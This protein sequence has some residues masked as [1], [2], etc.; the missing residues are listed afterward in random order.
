MSAWEDFKSF[1][2]ELF[3][4]QVRCPAVT[5]S[6]SGSPVRSIH[7]LFYSKN[8]KETVRGGGGRKFCNDTN[9]LP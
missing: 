1:D 2:A 5:F 7:H 3:D 9:R 8:G 6:K 4:K